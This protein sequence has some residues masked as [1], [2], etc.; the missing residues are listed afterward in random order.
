MCHVIT[1]YHHAAILDPPSPTCASCIE[2]TAIA[3]LQA[4]ELEEFLFGAKSSSARVFE[5]AEP[6]EEEDLTLADLLRKVR[7]RRQTAAVIPKAQ[8]R[9]DYETYRQCQTCGSLNAPSRQGAPKQHA[10]HT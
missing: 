9:L 5:R 1:C 10:W 3:I 8:D 6:E 7:L 2:R 4:A